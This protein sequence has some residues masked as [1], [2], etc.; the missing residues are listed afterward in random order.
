MKR[1]IT[2]INLALAI[3]LLAGLGCSSVP[4]SD[5]NPLQGTWK[6]EEIGGNAQG[7]C[8]L[9]I[10]GQTLE[11]RGADT[12][13]WYKGTFTLREE[14][15]PPQ[16]IGEIKDCPFPQVIGSTV[17]AIYEIK[18]GSMKLA[19]NEPGAP[20]APVSFDAAGARQFVFKKE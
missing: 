4:K 20:Q 15:K 8:Y 10:S 14:T 2:L 11:F 9:I 7:P 17:H 18:D 13:E 19:G 6:G 3:I 5:S 16:L 1:I 12:N